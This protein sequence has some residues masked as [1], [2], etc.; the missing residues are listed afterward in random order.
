MQAASIGCFLSSPPHLP[1]LAVFPPC[2]L[3]LNLSP[4]FPPLHQIPTLLLPLPPHLPPSSAPHPLPLPYSPFPLSPHST[5]SLQLLEEE[6][7]TILDD[8][9]VLRSEVLQSGDSG[10]NLP[11]NL[12]RLLWNAQTKFNCKQQ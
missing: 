8:L 9:R 11:V 3:L 1:A 2:F 7:R 10:V 6:Y 12:D 4:F 5:P